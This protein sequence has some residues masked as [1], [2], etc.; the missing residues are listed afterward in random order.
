MRVADGR[1][2][3]FI[4]IHWNVEVKV[5]VKMGEGNNGRP[6][7]IGNFSRKGRKAGG[8]SCKVPGSPSYDWCRN[9]WG[10]HR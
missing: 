9:R 4:A 3:A 10:R 7:A 5:K 2:A 1:S 6:Q 8:L